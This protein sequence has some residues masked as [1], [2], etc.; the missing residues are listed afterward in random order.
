MCKICPSYQVPKMSIFF[1]FNIRSSFMHLHIIKKRSKWQVLLIRNSYMTFWLN[2]KIINAYVQTFTN[3]LNCWW[4]SGI[5][6]HWY[7]LLNNYIRDCVFFT[8]MRFCCIVCQALLNYWVQDQDK[9]LLGVSFIRVAMLQYR[10]QVE[11]RW[12]HV[13][14]FSP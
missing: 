12:W 11:G 5:C 9:N 4:W 2:E 7:K 8:I 13:S 1:A 3:K 6:T 10:S 14:S